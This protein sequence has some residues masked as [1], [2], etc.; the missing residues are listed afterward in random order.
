MLRINCAGNSDIGLKRSNNEDSLVVEPGLGLLVV[1]DGM[2]GAASGEVAS[3]IF[4]DTSREVFL[5]G[6][7][8]SDET[9]SALVQKAFLLA[10]ER[11]LT[12]A[13][14]NRER[15]GMGC[16]A[17]LLALYDRGYI[18]GHVGDSRTYVLRQGR[19]RQITRDHS[20]VQE[21]IDAGLISPA[22]ARTHALKNVIVRAVGIKEALPVDLIKGISQP[23]D[24]FLLCSDG[25]TDM[26][27]DDQIQELLS[28]SLS[29]DE[30][31]RK[32]IEA[33]NSA[34]GYDNITVALC[35]VI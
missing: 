34:G 24:I 17:E 7:V 8:T 13:T 2:G 25:L 23:G 30:K 4:T 1:A 26:L 22:E 11:I 18:L 31:A 33:A 5:T 28:L 35:E 6:E 12:V 9:A 16:T 21:Q 14:E 27:V 20:L 32:L 19:L 29:A 15:K 3:K 10:N